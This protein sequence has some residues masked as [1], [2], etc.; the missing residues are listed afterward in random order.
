MI[1]SFLETS[2]ILE[3]ITKNDQTKEKKSVSPTNT[4][5]LQ[6]WTQLPQEVMVARVSTL[7]IAIGEVKSKEE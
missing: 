4:E 6:R 3:L 1:D 7:E 5:L 2:S